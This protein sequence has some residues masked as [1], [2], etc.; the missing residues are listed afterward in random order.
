MKRVAPLVI[1]TLA[2]IGVALSSAFLAPHFVR[3]SRDDALDIIEAA[4]D[5]SL[6]VSNAE[7]DGRLVPPM[8]EAAKPGH[9]KFIETKPCGAVAA[10]EDCVV[11]DVHLGEGKGRL[12]EA[13]WHDAAVNLESYEGISP[14]HPLPKVIDIRRL[15][16]SSASKL[17]RL[18]ITAS[19]LK[20]ETI[21]PSGLA[22]AEARKRISLRTDIPA[23]YLWIYSAPWVADDIAFIEVGFTCG[24]LCGRG[25]TYALR[26]ADG[27][28]RV[29]AVQPSWVS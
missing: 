23:H 22:T 24:D 4:A 10:S 2:A 3:P 14:A 18:Q 16:S 19:K 28:W 15:Q 17:A 27:K 5:Y 11:L 6:S 29:I 20:L 9:I 25:E 12:L 1:A 21:A 7:A 8:P 13:S 26:K